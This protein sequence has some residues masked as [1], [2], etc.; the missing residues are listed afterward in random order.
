M[1][2]DSNKDHLLKKLN[3]MHR[4][5]TLTEKSHS[6]RARLHEKDRAREQG[7]N[8]IEKA[9]EDSAKPK[10]LLYGVVRLFQGTIKSVLS[11]YCEVISFDIAEKATDY[12]FENHV[13]IVVL[14]MDPP[15]D[16]KL[17]HDLF[18]TGK[19]MYPDIEY[20]VFHK[21]KSVA[22]EIA[23]LQAQGARIMNKPI[24]QMDLIQAIKQI[25]KK[26]DTNA[27]KDD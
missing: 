2:F 11:S 21:E 9:K 12:I 3:T 23:M 10:V 14:D 25:V 26:Q 22:N 20:I 1:T 4:Q 6:A 24:N 17:C 8:S 5:K 19:T 27:K 15:N 16:W 18:T 7:Q 13:P